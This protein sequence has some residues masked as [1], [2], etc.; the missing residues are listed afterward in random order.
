MG[1]PRRKYLSVVYN[2]IDICNNLSPYIE[3]FSYEDSV[4]ES[5]TISIS[6]S[7]RDLK[8]SRTWLPEKGDKISPSI[9]LENWNYEG[10]KMTVL[11]GVFLVDD[12]S[13]SCPPFSCTINGVSAPVDTSFKE[14]ENTKTWEN[15]TVRLIANE[16]ASKYNLKLIF[17]VGEDITVSKTEQDKQADSEFLKNLCEKYGLGIKVYS[18]RLVIWV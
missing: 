18:N 3:S 17:E 15:A 13:F 9:I 2:G 8:W 7:D 12:Y 5:D 14:S 10:E 1:N 6:L 11:C 4:D 16:I